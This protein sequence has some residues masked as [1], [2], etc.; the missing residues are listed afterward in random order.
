MKKFYIYYFSIILG[1]LLL[2]NTYCI[3]QTVALANPDYVNSPS[4]SWTNNLNTNSWITFNSSSNKNS[5]SLIL[6]INNINNGESCISPSGN[7]YSN[8]PS[9]CFTKSN[10]ESIPVSETIVNDRSFNQFGLNQFDEKR[11]FILNS[12]KNGNT[13][14]QYINV[15][16]DYYK[17]TNFEDGQ[18]VRLTFTF[19]L[20]IANG[21]TDTE[22]NILLNDAF[23]KN[24]FSVYFANY[25]SGD[26]IDNGQIAIYDPANNNF[27]NP[28]GASGLESIYIE[29]WFDDYNYEMCFNTNGDC[30]STRGVA[31][32]LYITVQIEFNWSSNFNTNKNRIHFLF[33]S[34]VFNNSNNGFYA[35][36]SLNLFHSIYMPTLDKVGINPDD[37]RLFYTKQIEMLNLKKDNSSYII[38]G[39]PN[40]N[41]ANKIFMKGCMS[42]DGEYI[43]GTSLF[44]S[45]VFRYTGGNT[46]NSTTLL[47]NMNP[48]N[49]NAWD[50]GLSQ[51]GNIDYGEYLDYTNNTPLIIMLSTNI[52]YEPQNVQE[53][54]KSLWSYIKKIFTNNSNSTTTNSGGGF[55]SGIGTGMHEK[56]TPTINS[57]Q[58]TYCDFRIPKGIQMN[59][60][61]YNYNNNYEI[62]SVTSSIYD[63]YSNTWQTFTSN[64]MINGDNISDYD[65]S[66]IDL[67]TLNTS[68]I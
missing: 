18:R 52:Y 27:N 2:N 63:N 23:N 30:S 22:H 44:N 50:L 25:S 47:Q 59:P 32:N 28:Y 61:I 38:S 17:K 54:D 49:F 46:F 24:N 8:S 1:I 39:I 57:Y 55:T 67:S 11:G 15:I 12:L 41:I 60:I 43:N 37:D 21:Y 65:L 4:T 42:L 40:D 13:T 66:N 31:V 62:T 68:L 7:Y 26:N 20:G 14:D 16:S 3:P 34:S 58:V 51:T 48:I 64:E 35:N 6:G 5:N 29:D 9:S 36:N 10:L 19:V 45:S 56:I 53:K 33:Y